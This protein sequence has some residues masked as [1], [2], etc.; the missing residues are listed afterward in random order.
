[1]GLFKWFNDALSGNYVKGNETDG[2]VINPSHSL[3]LI[4]KGV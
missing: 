2:F 4:I 3:K 1:M